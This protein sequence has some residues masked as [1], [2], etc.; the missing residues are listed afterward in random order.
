MTG[1]DAVAV[2]LLGLEAEVVRA[3]DDEAVELHERIFI[4]QKIEPLARRELSLLV[5]RLE[6]SVT[7]SLLRLG[8]AALEEGEFVP[9]GH[10][11][12]KLTIERGGI[13]PLASTG[14]RDGE[15]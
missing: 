11:P 15:P 10:R 4:E 13:H 1:N 2:V 9:H 7:A 14:R 5:L 8:A 6:A 3:M 12:E